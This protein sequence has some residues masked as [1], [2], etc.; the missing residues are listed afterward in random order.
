MHVYTWTRRPLGPS[1]CRAIS[2]SRGYKGPGVPG[3]HG[4]TLPA[5]SQSLSFG[6]A[7]RRHGESSIRAA[8]GVWVWEPRFS[9]D[10]GDGEARPPSPSGGRRQVEGQHGPVTTMLG[11]SSV[12]EAGLCAQFP[13]CEAAPQHVCTRASPCL[14]CM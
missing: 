5:G 9:R 4:A 13:S 11:C 3:P 10:S 14:I 2:G 12:S 7:P 6:W 1:G 8:D